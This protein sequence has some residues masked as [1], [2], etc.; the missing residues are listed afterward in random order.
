MLQ[1]NLRKEYNLN[2]VKFQW[3]ARDG[4]E[5]FA[6]KWDAGKNSR[7]A[8]LLVHGLGEH[9]SRYAKWASKLVEEGIS[10]LSFDFRGH[11]QTPGKPGQISDY[12]KLLDDVDLL[13]E[14]GKDEFKINN[15][16]CTATAWGETWLPIMLLCI[17]QTYVA[18]YSPHPGSSSPTF[19]RY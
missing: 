19:L 16:F 10:V 9:S 5:L 15:Y 8:I 4:K 13:I 1:S 6:Q 3:Q 12:H 2:H 17:Q 18:S 14:K 7:A 11:G